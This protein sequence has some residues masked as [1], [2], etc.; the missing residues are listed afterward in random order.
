MAGDVLQT[1]FEFTLPQGFVDDEGV[2]H[3]EGVMRLA[4]AADEIKP[5]QD[6][7]VQANE[8][9]LTIILLSRVLTRL[10]TFDTVTPHVVENVFVE[11]LQFL[12]DLYQRVNG[13][14]THVDATCPD[15]GAAFTVAPADPGGG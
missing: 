4:T 9:Y 3:R 10:G 15:C 6:P 12:Q 14:Q 1:E 5:L 8:S 11:D 7:R 13:G 2:R